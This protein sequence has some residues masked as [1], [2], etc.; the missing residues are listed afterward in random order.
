MDTIEAEELQKLRNV[1]DKI[2]CKAGYCLR[3]SRKIL[4]TLQKLNDALPRTNTDFAAQS[5]R[6]AQHIQVMLDR[7]DGHINSVDILAE[8]VQATLGMVSR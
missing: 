7:L 1:Q 5:D 2:V 3:S 8:R 4:E 6:I